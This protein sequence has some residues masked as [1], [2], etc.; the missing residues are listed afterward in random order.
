MSCDGCAYE[1]VNCCTLLHC[2]S[3]AH[4]GIKLNLQKHY[5]VKKCLYFMDL[6]IQIH[7]NKLE[8]RGKVHLFQ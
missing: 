7:V 4:K 6:Y 5:A 1:T 8:C 2:S 3:T